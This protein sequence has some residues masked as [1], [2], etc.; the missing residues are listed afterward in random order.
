MAYIGR[1]V[2]E[3]NSL[4]CKDIVIYGFGQR[5]ESFRTTAPEHLP[6]S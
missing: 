5:T 2:K 6:F 1:L 4:G 3:W